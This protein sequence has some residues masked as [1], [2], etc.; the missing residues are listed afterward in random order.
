VT[1][2]PVQ[3]APSSLSSSRLNQVHAEAV[4]HWRERVIAA[5]EAAG[6]VKFAF[7]SDVGV[8]GR[9]RPGRHRDR[10]AAG[11]THRRVR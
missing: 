5:S 1:S 10:R 2:R 11:M 9:A 4:G 7:G 3:N 6:P 8:V